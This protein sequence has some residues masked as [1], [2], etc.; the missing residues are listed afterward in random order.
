MP[1]PASSQGREPGASSSGSGKG[2]SVVAVILD[3]S[4]VHS[5]TA[6]SAPPSPTPSSSLARSQQPPPAIPDYDLLARIGGGSY[7]EV[8]IGRTA[9]GTCHAIKFVYRSSFDHDRPYEREF[10]GMRKFEPISRSHPNL[11]AV[12]HVGRNDAAGYFYY[13]MELADDA[14]ANS[15]SEIRNPKE[16][17]SSDAVKRD[18][19]KPLPQSGW[20]I[21]RTLR[22]DLRTRGRLTVPECLELGLAL[23]DALAHLHRH[24]LVH[25]DV[26][27]SNII[28]VNG[29]PKLADIG[30]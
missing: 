13:V 5:S 8:W 9:I 22:Q 16:N 15:K 25:R 30:R 7:G 24:G 6:S 2:N 29:V 26:K 3:Q 14:A 10:S 20:Y 11:V 4:D 28:F 1:D 23:T 19:Q 17:Q 12:L 27:P 18:D 21:P